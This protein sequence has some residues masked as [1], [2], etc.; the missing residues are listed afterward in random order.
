MDK[1]CSVYR[2]GIPD[3]DEILSRFSSGDSPS[4]LV[5]VR[6]ISEGSVDG[7]LKGDLTLL[8]DHQLRRKEK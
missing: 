8:I 4:V 1:Q 2:W 3:R 7:I 5:N 6:L